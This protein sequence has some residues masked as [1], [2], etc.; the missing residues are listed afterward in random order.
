MEPQDTDPATMLARRIALLAISLTS[1]LTP[2]MAS[3]VNIALPGIAE[4]FQVSAVLLSW[5][6]TAY[7]L[8]TAVFLVP[9]GTLADIYGRKRIYILG[10]V[11]Y[12]LASGLCA[13]APSGPAL[14][15]AR[16]GQG[17]GSAMIFGT[18]IAIL[19]SIFPS[20]Q[21]GQ[22]LGINTAAVYIGLSAGPFLGGLLVGQWGWRSVFWIN[23]PLGGIALLV[24]LCKVRGE[25]AGSPGAPFDLAGSAIYGIATVAAMYG[26]SLLPQPI[27]AWLILVGFA[28]GAA[29]VWQ[30]G[31]I[32]R[33]V[34]DLALFRGHRTFTL[35]SIAALINYAATSSV[36][37]L[38]SL[39]LQ[40]IKGMSPRQAGAVLI[41]QPI[42]MAIFSPLAGRLSDH[43][44]PRLIASAGMALTVVGLALLSALGEDTGLAYILGSLVILGLG[45][46]FFS[47]P[48]TSAIMGSVE[49]RYHGVASGMVGTMRLFGQ[50]LSM[51]LAML[52]FSL[53][54]GRVQITPEY[55]GRFLQSVRTDWIISALLC[56]LGIL[57]SLARG[58]V[59]MPSMN[60]S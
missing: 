39:Y 16:A 40:Y 58:R 59:Q 42:L 51:G 53:Y 4:H 1:F 38:L 36:T 35:S 34:L 6:A 47:S 32:A 17:V 3:S 24:T 25:W 12:S 60:R 29:F 49:R 5:V 14:I 48:N 20:E 19:T 45:F 9:F 2:F 18:G 54:M 30:E 21:R 52:L 55:Y 28:A 31:R 46:A 10:I 50:M 41:A 37:F 57:A 7:S 23:V 33:P 27:G 56:L 26:L 22:V 43:I 44:E 8:A 11:L 15:A 13:L